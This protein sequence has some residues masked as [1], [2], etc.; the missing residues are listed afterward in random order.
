M[1]PGEANG[2]GILRCVKMRDMR[3]TWK[4]IDH[5]SWISL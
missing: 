4:F 5:R 1:M 2:Y 3:L